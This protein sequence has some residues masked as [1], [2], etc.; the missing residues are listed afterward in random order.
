MLLQDC[1]N[2]H[3][4]FDIKMNLCFTKIN[5]ELFFYCYL[6]YVSLK[7]K[8]MMVD[9]FERETFKSRDRN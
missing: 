4:S 5:L 6:N 8:W 9:W 1:H 7:L 3:V 2:C